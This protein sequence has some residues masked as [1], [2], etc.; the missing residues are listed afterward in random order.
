[1]QEVAVYEQWLELRK[2]VKAWPAGKEVSTQGI[3][4]CADTGRQ[5]FVNITK[6]E[7]L[8]VLDTRVSAAMDT[9]LELGVEV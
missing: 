2:A 3:E 8:C 6:D 4:V 1:M 5:G 7:I 9:L